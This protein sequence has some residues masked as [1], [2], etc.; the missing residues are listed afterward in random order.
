MLFISYPRTGV[1]FITTAIEQQTG[2]KIPYQHTIDTK[3]SKLLNIV[4]DPK[5]SI[6]S[7]MTMQYFLDDPILHNNSHNKIIK[8]FAIPKYVK[9]YDFLLKNDVVFINYKDY[10]KIDVLLLKLYE[11]LDISPTK[12]AILHEEIDKQNSSLKDYLITSKN[13]DRYQEIK[14]DIEHIELDT[15]YQYYD[16]ALKR[17]LSL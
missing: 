6:V 17:C 9:M 16:L 4:R 8:N 12:N 7:W 13:Q 2:V 14:E 5:E 3:E 15:C 11:I 10:D 1:N